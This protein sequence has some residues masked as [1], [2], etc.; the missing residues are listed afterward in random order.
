MTP[1]S[2]PQQITEKI[3]IA[4]EEQIPENELSITPI[5]IPTVKER[6][7]TQATIQSP[8]ISK[9][10]TKSLE[11]PKRI[12]APTKKIT[13]VEK[14]WKEKESVEKKTKEPI[15]SKHIEPSALPKTSSLLT[16][17]SVGSKTVEGT[18]PIILEEQ[19][20]IEPIKVA[21]TKEAY[22]ANEALIK[23]EST[24]TEED[25]VAFIAQLRD[26]G[27]KVKVSKKRVQDEIYKL[28]LRL[29]HRKGLH[30]DMKIRCFERLEFKVILKE[31]EKRKKAE[32]IAYRVNSME[33]F[34]KYLTMSEKGRSKHVFHKDT[35]SSRHKF[36]KE[37]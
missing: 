13:T 27:I 22:V 18:A 24:A 35:K 20:N 8:D 15:L 23:L 17:Q 32:K 25:L 29:T 34:S 1:I 3:A 9:K 33:K 10:E 4:K 2:E 16:V 11:T 14:D 6:E 30:W 37:Y 28:N 12:I 36:S 26:Y 19:L 5:S 7:L 21:P 31:S